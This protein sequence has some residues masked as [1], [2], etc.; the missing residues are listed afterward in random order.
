MTRL[1]PGTLF[2]ADLCQS[3]PHGGQ[4]LAV[5]LR[6]GQFLAG[7]DSLLKAL[8]SGE[9]PPAFL[10]VKSH[11][12]LP[13]LSWTAPVE[14]RNRAAMS[15]VPPSGRVED[16]S[17]PS[18]SA[19]W[20]RICYAAIGLRTIRLGGARNVSCRDPETSHRK[21]TGSPSFC[22]GCTASAQCRARALLMD[23]SP[24][25]R[26]RRAH[27]PSLAL[28]PHICAALHE[29]S[30]DWPP[31]RHGSSPGPG[32]DLRFATSG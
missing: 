24:F 30:R 18:G 2:P 3:P 7:S 4:L 16:R 25:R 19:L 23:L 28:R 31:A 10:L 17:A 26:D 12:R 14:R 15:G 27:W 13:F 29:P 9:R 20:G 8:R 1:R 11:L 22:P 21:C 5:G 32:R 6:L